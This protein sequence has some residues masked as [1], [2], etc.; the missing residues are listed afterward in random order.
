MT[1]DKISK[2]VNVL[3]NIKGC[4]IW[5]L[6]TRSPEG[7]IRCEFRSQ[8]LNIQKIAVKY[9]GGGHRCASG[10]RLDNWSWD[11]CMKIINDLDDL[12]KRGD[13]GE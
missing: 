11:E 13:D 10:A 7:F 4:P 9:G 1:F 5:I 12:A 3:G 2:N 6:M 8:T